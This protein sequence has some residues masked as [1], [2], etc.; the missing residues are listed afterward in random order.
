[1]SC[2]WQKQAILNALRTQEQKV[3]EETRKMQAAE[4]AA[5]LHQV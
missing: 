5:A 1:M 3:E 2:T 4:E